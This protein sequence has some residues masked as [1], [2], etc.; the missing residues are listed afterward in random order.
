M[1]Y[2]ARALVCT[3]DGQALVSLEVVQSS[4]FSVSEVL[5]S[6]AGR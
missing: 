6:V 1:D 5:P 4:S 2:D 3:F